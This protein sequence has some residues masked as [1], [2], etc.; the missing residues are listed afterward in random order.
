M[1]LI[2]K[3]EGEEYILFEDFQ[4][5]FMSI[6]SINQTRCEFSFCKLL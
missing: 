2:K 3:V 6:F 1:C 4:K 5:D